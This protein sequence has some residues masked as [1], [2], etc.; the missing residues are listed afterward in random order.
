MYPGKAG[1]SPAVAT[2][3]SIMVN[4]MMPVI[5]ILEF[6]LIFFFNSILLSSSNPVF[7]KA[8]D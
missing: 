6:S 3:T 8:K 5:P 4:K 7:S 2:G 1:M